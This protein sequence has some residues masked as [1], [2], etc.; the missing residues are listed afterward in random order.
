MHRQRANDDWREGSLRHWHVV[1]P[2]LGRHVV[3]EARLSS[4]GVD[5]TTTRVPEIALRRNTSRQLL[6]Y[7]RQFKSVKCYF[8]VV[9]ITK[10]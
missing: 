5:E 9:D 8:F 3:R 6:P 4:G 10:V 7:V 1:A 2:S